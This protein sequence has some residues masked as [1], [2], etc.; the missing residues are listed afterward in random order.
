MGLKGLTEEMVNSLERW[1]CPRCFVCSL[2]EPKKTADGAENR[3]L[4]LLIKEELHLINPVI[5][6]TIQNDPVT[7]FAKS[8]V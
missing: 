2:V 6:S 1:H 4:Q 5:R 7:Y 8:S 3:T